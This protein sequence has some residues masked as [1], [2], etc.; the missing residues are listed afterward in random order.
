M[1]NL[2]K[3]FYG[4]SL[5]VLAFSLVGTTN[6][7]AQ[8]CVAPPNCATLG[9]TKT[10]AECEGKD[11]LK[12]PFDSNALYCP[13]AVPETPP[14]GWA[15]GDVYKINNVA[16]G[17]VKSCSTSTILPFFGSGYGYGYDSPCG[18]GIGM[19]VG[20]CMSALGITV[21]TRKQIA[22]I[23]NGLYQWVYEGATD[24]S[25]SFTAFSMGCGP[26]E[27]P[28]NEALFCNLDGKNIKKTR[29]TKGLII[30]TD[31]IKTATSNDEA[32]AACRAKTTGGLS[33]TL[34]A[35]PYPTS[36][37]TPVGISL[38]WAYSNGCTVNNSFH[39]IN[40]FSYNLECRG[41][42]N[43]RFYRYQCVAVF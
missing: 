32:I 16:V 11:I 3:N 34:P 13:G 4:V 40:D 43:G 5:A 14:V 24:S 27:S 21:H 38:V 23:G 30:D 17:I 8:T 35:A 20:D 19:S 33:W 42:A 12:C 25:S 7:H 2:K 15:I 1:S 41:A 18:Q 26:T 29:C 6:A 22:N 28:N 39:G 9:F 31:G 37:S 36:G 10:A